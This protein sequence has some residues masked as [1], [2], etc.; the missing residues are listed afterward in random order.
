[1]KYSIMLAMIGIASLSMCSISAEGADE[2]VGGGGEPEPVDAAMTVQEVESADPDSATVNDDVNPE[3]VAD[4]DSD[5]D[6]DD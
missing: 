6:F 4:D 2:N 5:D 3:G 1:M